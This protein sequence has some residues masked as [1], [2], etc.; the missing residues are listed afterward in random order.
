VYFEGMQMIVNVSPEAEKILGE[1]A[2]RNGK[3]APEM[4]GQWPGDE[5]DEEVLAALEK[6]S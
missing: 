5:T 6:L 4:A 3:P 1:L 2:D